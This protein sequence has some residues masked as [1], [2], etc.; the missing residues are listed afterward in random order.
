MRILDRYLIRGFLYP[1]VYCLVLFTMLFVIVDVFDKLDEYLKSTLP[2]TVIL[3]YYLYS[4]PVVLT[5]IVPVAVLVAILYKLGNLN[6]HN[7]IV[8]LKA[9][10]ISTLH[11]LLPYLFAG[12]LISF[13]ML[14]MNETV[15]PRAALTSTAI[16]EGQIQKGGKSGGRAIKNVTLYG[17]DQRMIFARELE[18]A[19]GTL[20]DVV[21]LREGEDR[22]PRSKLA[23]KSARYEDGRWIF[24]DVIRYRLDR[25]GKLVGEPEFS[26]ELPLDMPET[27]ADFVRGASQVETM[28]AKEL[29]RY[30]GQFAGSSR[31]VLRRLWVEFHQ[32]IAFPFVSFVVMLVGA[33]LAMRTE[34]GSALVG[35]GTALVVVV[36]YYGVNSVCLALGKGGHLDPV[37]AAWLSNFLFGAVGLALIRRSA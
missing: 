27:P 16:L 36:L 29:E 17:T 30:I 37:I 9:S 25:A 23:A 26:E 18:I 1:F 7:E 19:T 31:Q 2:Y 4:L 22:T 6:R 33:P 34:R 35:I 8:A 24:R 12:V 20:H 5:H 28:S 11:I 13:A 15:L 21:I 32:K 3:Q 10:G 14:L